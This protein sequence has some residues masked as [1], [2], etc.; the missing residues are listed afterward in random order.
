[1]PTRVFILVKCSCFLLAQV[2]ASVR[3]DWYLTFVSMSALIV[4]WFRVGYIQNWKRFA[5]CFE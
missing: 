4:A 5:A 2:V 3:Q 1:M